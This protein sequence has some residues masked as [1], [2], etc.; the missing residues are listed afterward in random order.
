MNLSIWLH[1]NFAQVINQ[2]IFYSRPIQA[3]RVGLDFLIRQTQPLIHCKCQCQWIIFYV[4]EVRLEQIEEGTFQQKTKNSNMAGGRRQ[5]T[6]AR[7]KVST[8][9]G[10]WQVR[11]YVCDTTWTSVRGAIASNIYIWMDKF[12]QKACYKF[13]CI[14]L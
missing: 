8:K 12:A 11:V 5:T 9:S 7:R 14:L 3:R 2:K 6:G 1:I 13:M 4:S 10:N